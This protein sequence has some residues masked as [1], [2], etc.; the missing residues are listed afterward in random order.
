MTACEFL[1]ESETSA[2]QMTDGKVILPDGK[3]ASPDEAI[4]LRNVSLT[5]SPRVTRAHPTIVAYAYFPL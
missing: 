2:V 3:V 5:E 1:S 4:E